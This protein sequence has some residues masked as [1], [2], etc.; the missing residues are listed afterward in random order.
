MS[1][2]LFIG[3]D[4]SKIGG[5]G[6]IAVLSSDAPT[7]GDVHCC[8]MPATERDTWELIECYADRSAFAYIEWINPAIQNIGKSHMS[9]L[10]GGY[11]ALRMALI[12]ARIPFEDVKPLKWQ[13]GLGIPSRAKSESDTQWKERLKGVAQQIFPHLPIWS[14]PRSKGRQLAIAD[15]LLIAEFCRR[16]SMG[17]LK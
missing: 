5:Q 6:G 3:I 16:V 4:P 9:K 10:Y 14:E 1:A 8:G 7:T 15:A 13:R 17:E 2:Q 12:A 11:S